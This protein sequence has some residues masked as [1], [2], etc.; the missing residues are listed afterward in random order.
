[1]KVVVGKPR[2]KVSKREEEISKLV[3]STN[4]YVEVK[5]MAS[6]FTSVAYTL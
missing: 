5:P 6:L 4:L 1:M 3:D 2:N